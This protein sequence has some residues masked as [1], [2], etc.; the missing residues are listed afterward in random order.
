MQTFQQILHTRKEQS[1]N[2]HGMI[3]IDLLLLSST[4]KT[5]FY[6]K[7]FSYHGNIGYQ[8]NSK[9]SGDPMYAK[10]MANGKSIITYTTLSTRGGAFAP[11]L[12]GYC[13][14]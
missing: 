5:S 2:T 12:K 1:Q 8:K 7:R 10:C 3:A 4:Y 14:K 9:Y 11:C 13:E 6:V